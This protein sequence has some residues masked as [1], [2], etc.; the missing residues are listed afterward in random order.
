LLIGLTGGIATGKST[1][2]K[3]LKDLGVEIIDADQIAHNVLKN[4]EVVK[5]IKKEFGFH[6]LDDN[7]EIDRKK[8][9]QVVF[10]DQKKLKK[11]ESFTHPKIF[12]IIKNRLEVLDTDNKLVVLDAP[13]LFEVAL[14]KEVDE[15]WVIYADKK[16]QIKRI[17]KRD[18]LTK[19]EAEK[20]IDTQMPLNKKIEKADVVIDNEGSIKSLR[21]KIKKL[22]EKRS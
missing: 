19:K 6:I 16:T 4:K 17:V 5:N 20:R 15:T 3:I 8:L 14:D 9:G 22:V 1:V 21:E 10:N 7:G 12:E 11:L 2:C 18:N 13:L